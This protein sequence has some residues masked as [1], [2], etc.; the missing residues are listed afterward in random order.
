M[1]DSKK[2]SLGKYPIKYSNIACFILF[3]VGLMFII[4]AAYRVIDINSIGGI[5]AWGYKEKFINSDVSLIESLKLQDYEYGYGIL[6]WLF[7]CLTSNYSVVQI[8]IYIIMFTALVSYLRYLT[9]NKTSFLMLIML[10]SM[11]IDSFNII[12][13]DFAVFIGLFVYIFLY[14]GKIKTAFFLSIIATSIHMA[15]LILFP[16][17]GVYILFKKKETIS[18]KKMIFFLILLI[19]IALIGLSLAGSF[20]SGSRYNAY[21]YSEKEMAT[22]TYLMIVF[23]SSASIKKY[24]ELKALNPIY[25]VFV[26]VLPFGLIVLPLQLYY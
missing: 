13:V 20:I 7:R 1:L 23:I 3:G 19:M 18:L 17:I 10:Y 12:R 24:K 8:V 21:N 9:W 6:I 11:Y 5:D 4:I 25:D 14:K 2:R 15:S 16:L 26:K 22:S